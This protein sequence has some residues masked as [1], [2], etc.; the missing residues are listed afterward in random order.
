VRF[1]DLTM[2][3]RGAFLGDKKGRTWR[4]VGVYLP[5]YTCL[6]IMHRDKSKLWHWWTWWILSYG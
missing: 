5:S 1:Q 4:W 3:I 2:C 6:H